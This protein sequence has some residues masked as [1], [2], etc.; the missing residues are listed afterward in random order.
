MGRWTQYDEVLQPSLYCIH[1]SL[2]LVVQDSYRLPSGTTRIG[3]DADTGCYSYRDAS[4]RTYTGEPGSRYGPMHPEGTEF[5]PKRVLVPVTE[6]APKESVR[7]RFSLPMPDV[8]AALRNL[9]RSMTVRQHRDESSDD[10]EFVSVR[11][12]SYKDLSS[13]PIAARFMAS[14]DSPPALQPSSPSSTAPP[15]PPPKESKKRRHASEHIPSTS[16]SIPNDA[17]Q[18]STQQPLPSKRRSASEHIPSS[19]LSSA[20]S[21]P[22][23]IS[24]DAPLLIRILS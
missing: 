10:E 16:S 17:S 8:S 11:A 4:G 19:R 24:K 12:P 23:P 21:A 3:Y 13:L 9:R 5:G 7:R 14:K 6:R 15:A 22:A 18:K 2:T 20:S 1:K